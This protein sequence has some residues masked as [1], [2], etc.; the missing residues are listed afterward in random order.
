MTYQMGSVY[1]ISLGIH[2]I[3]FSH[4][5]GETYEKKFHMV[6]FN[7]NNSDNN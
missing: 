4:E 3:H 5:K 1:H 2:L 6:T 7:D